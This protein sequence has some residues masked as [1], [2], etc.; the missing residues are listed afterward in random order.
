MN[1]N[2]EELKKETG[3]VLVEVYATWCPHCQKMMPV[4][5]DVIK[6]LAGRANVYKFDIDKFRDF[7]DE[8]NVES[9][10]TFIVFK[11]GDEKWRFSGEMEED[12][13]LKKVE[14]YL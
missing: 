3:T 5:E 1:S 10:P 14:E 6:R 8:L 11:G 12:A 4:V 2:L 9:I 7:A 13:L